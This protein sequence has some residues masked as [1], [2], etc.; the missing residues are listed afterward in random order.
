M[1][2]NSYQ[3]ILFLGNRAFEVFKTFHSVT[4]KSNHLTFSSAIPFSGLKNT[5]LFN[6]LKFETNCD[7]EF[8]CLKN[9][10]VSLIQSKQ[11]STS[12]KLIVGDPS[13]LIYQ[14]FCCALL[15]TQ[16]YTESE[17]HE[18]HLW[19]YPMGMTS[20]DIRKELSQL[21]YKLKKQ[22]TPILLLRKPIQESTEILNAIFTKINSSTFYEL[23]EKMNGLE[24]LIG[25]RSANLIDG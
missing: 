21:I 9:K 15:E 20:Q 25:K 23:E 4:S 1:N 6:D 3:P 13:E 5:I 8:E 17:F 2:S 22:E 19:L 16:L 24:F 10:F 11:I 7:Y 18:I 12:F 14:A